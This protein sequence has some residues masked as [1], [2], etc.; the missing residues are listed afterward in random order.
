MLVGLAFLPPAKAEPLGRA[1]SE[2]NYLLD[3]IEISGCQFLR[4]GSW[5]DSGKAQ[6]HLRDKYNYLSARHKINSAEDFIGMAATKSS[7][8][9][10][11]YEVQCDSACTVPQPSG[12]WLTGVLAR[13]RIVMARQYEPVEKTTGLVHE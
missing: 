9:G 1:E 5:Y 2:I 11:A 7:L 12:E 4:N 10:R 8:S 13:Y 6:E 3:F